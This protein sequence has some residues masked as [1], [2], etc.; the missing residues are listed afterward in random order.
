MSSQTSVDRF[1]TVAD[2]ELVAAGRSYSVAQVARDFIILETAVEI[3]PGPATLVIRV[4][5]EELRRDIELPDGANR[6][7]ERVRIVR[8]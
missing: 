5:G 2:F 7:S 4:N 6:S 1:S 3:A 8:R